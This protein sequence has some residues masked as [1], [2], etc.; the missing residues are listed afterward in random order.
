MY[1][2]LSEF[3][4]SVLG[5]PAMN[6]GDDICASNFLSYGGEGK[7]N[8]SIWFSSFAFDF[9]QPPVPFSIRA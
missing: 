6:Y 8:K 7:L 4:L 9:V 3:G 5:W 2:Y 1:I